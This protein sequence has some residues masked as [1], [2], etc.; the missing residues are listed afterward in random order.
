MLKNTLLGF[1]L[2]LLGWSVLVNL[3]PA[4]I[5]TKQNQWN[6]NLIKAETYL[7]EQPELTNTAVILGS[8]MSAR[9]PINKANDSLINLAFDGLSA[10]DGIEL[11]LTKTQKPTTVYIEINTIFKERNEEFHD[12]LFSPIQN[13]LKSAFDAFLTKNQPVAILKG[14]IH[15]K[16]DRR[17]EANVLPVAE[18]PPIVNQM[19]LSSSIKMY[20][21]YPSD[22]VITARLNRL[23]SL[24][25][26]LEKQ[27]CNV[28]FFEMPVHPSLCQSA[29]SIR[30]RYELYRR[31]PK[32][33]FTYIPQPDCDQFHTNDGIHLTAVSA[34]LYASYVTSKRLRLDHPE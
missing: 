26:A 28:V 29:L 33:R 16:K 12:A 10:Y 9:V 8:S 18:V 22:N 4:D 24:I 2:L 32:E 31:F 5:D 30:I 15:Y 23:A 13:W 25:N 20:A 19:M 34:A 27:G 3:L 14:L 17:T 7:F 11:V 6:S 1:V 21:S